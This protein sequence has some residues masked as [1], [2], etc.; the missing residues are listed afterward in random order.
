[1][2]ATPQLSHVTPHEWFLAIPDWAREA[3]H[4]FFCRS[5]FR[6]FSWISQIFIAI[7]IEELSCFGHLY[8]Y[9]PYQVMYI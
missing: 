2:P 6:G 8:I 3:V 5:D 9:S 7:C 1:M 4:F